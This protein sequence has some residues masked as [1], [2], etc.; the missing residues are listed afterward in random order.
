MEAGA[1]DSDGAAFCGDG[2]FVRGGVDAAGE[3][4]DDGESGAGELEG[5]L[6]GGFAAVVGEFT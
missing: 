5:E 4:G 1:E 3:A 2:S 6:A